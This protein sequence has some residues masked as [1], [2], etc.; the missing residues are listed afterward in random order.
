[1]YRKFYGGDCPYKGRIRTGN[2]TEDECHRWLSD[3][4]TN[5]R[6]GRKIIPSGNVYQTLA[7]YCAKHPSAVSPRGKFSMDECERWLKDKGRNPRTGRLIKKHGRIYKTLQYYCD[8][9]RIGKTVC[10]H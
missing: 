8:F 6:T 9:Y 4:T 3:K 7:Y 1:M 2:F 10:K 5:P